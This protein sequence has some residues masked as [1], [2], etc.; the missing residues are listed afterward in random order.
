MEA[1]TE[2]LVKGM[3]V[4][5]V[6]CLAKLITQVENERVNIPG[7]ME[8]LASHL[9]RTYCVGITGAPGVGKSTLTDALVAVA[10]KNGLSVG[11]VAADPSS[12]L[13]GGAV[14]GDRIRMEQHFVDKEVF[15]RSM[16]TRGHYGGL[17][18]ATGH[19]VKLLDAFGKDLVIVET[20]GV[21]QTELG[22]TEVADAIVLV[23]SP[24]SG[25][26]IQFM[27]AGIMEVADIL[28]VNKADHGNAEGIA[29]ELKTML[30][31]SPD[32]SRE[33]TPILMT[34]ALNRIGIDELY[35][36]LEKCRQGKQCGQKLRELAVKEPPAPD[37]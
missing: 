12:P 27:K 31:M 15:I 28:V 14:L 18:R 24:E 3:L 2:E 7:I 10:R 34:Q 36:A 29:F 30:R 37:A 16:A 11:I 19:V 22:I 17:P 25:D 4:G 21:G 33:E 23:L 8:R 9:G 20:V 26:S 1:D 32:R 5:S 35:Q 13:H 6:V